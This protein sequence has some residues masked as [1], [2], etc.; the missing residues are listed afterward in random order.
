MATKARA[1][2]SAATRSA[3]ALVDFV[4][5]QNWAAVD[6]DTRAIALHEINKAITK[7]RERMN[8]K[9]PICDPLPGE[10]MNA[11]QTIRAIATKFPANSGKANPEGMSG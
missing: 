7:V 3:R 11:F 10:R 2:L 4:A 8:E 9:E 5:A 6:S 1:R